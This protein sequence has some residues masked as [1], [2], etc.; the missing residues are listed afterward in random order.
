MQY[1]NRSL[2]T[3]CKENQMRPNY[4]K[5]HL[6]N[7]KGNITAPID[8]HKLDQL[9]N[10]Q[11]LGLQ[12]SE[13]LNWNENCSFRKRKGLCAFSRLKNISQKC[14]QTKLNAYLGNVVAI[15]TYSSQ[16]W[17]PNEL[18]MKEFEKLQKIATKCHKAKSRA[19]NSDLLS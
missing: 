3:W 5:T 17:F 7:I 9:K 19:I 16:A 14:E 15:V 2:F 12:V 6:L 13:N 1:W 11:D 18:E 10:Q 8:N 4:N